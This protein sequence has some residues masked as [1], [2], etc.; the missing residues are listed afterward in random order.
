[1]IAL[2]NVKVSVRL[3]I[4]FML[5]AAFGAVIGVV[6]I[7]NIR[8]ITGLAEGMY[9]RHVLGLA[10][11]EEASRDVLHAVYAE[12]NLMLAQSEDQRQ[13]SKAQYDESLKQLDDAMANAKRL[14]LSDEGKKVIARLESSLKDWRDASQ[15]TVAAAM[16]EPLTSSR[17]AA[18]VSSQAEDDK[19][20]VVDLGMT[21]LTNLKKK[22]ARGLADAMGKIAQTN[23]RIMICLVVGSVVL[24][25]LVGIGLAS[26][27]ARQLGCEPSEM[28]EMAGRISRGDL[29][30]G[31][32]ARR[33]RNAIGAFASLQEMRGWLIQIVTTIQ[34]CASQ[35]SASSEQIA[36]SAQKLAEGT[37][38][39]ASAVEETSASMEELSASVD[40][41][42]EKARAQSAAMELGSTS[43]AQVQSSIA[44]ASEN[45]EEIGNLA[46]ESVDNALAGGRS[47]EEVV[48][49]INEIAGSSERIGGI[50]SVISDIADQTNL[51][52]LNASIEA[53]RAGEHGRG[54]AVVAQEVG[55]LA[56]RSSTSTKEIEGLIRESAKNVAKGVGTASVSQKAMEQ[57]RVA[58]ERVKEMIGRVSASMSHQVEVVAE[59]SQAVENAKTTSKDISATTDE[60]AA[61]ARQVAEA[62]ERVNEWSQNAA[63]AAEEV[64]ASTE[65]LSRT[66]QT[67]QE[68]VQRFKV[69][70]ERAATPRSSL[71]S[72]LPV[73]T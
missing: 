28:M 59:F 55:K 5:V 54:F 8:S 29:T 61:S 31:L 33:K 65:L 18:S 38:S 7:A 69:R 26:G 66:S 30:V 22:N 20:K 9:N 21:D 53:A 24:G 64:S 63:S 1:M 32:E 34:D 67:L 14:T 46:G 3:T 50:L 70:E 58:S 12:R 40:Q 62:V 73:A 51:L 45:V 49:G 15:D 16:S 52:A 6:A 19:L 42:A 57:I 36:A 44:Q 68:L 4:G 47:V 13:G 37:Q 56:E 43:M 35:V 71:A 11:S 39:Q 17:R 25:I 10:S 72:A 2:K 60:Q 41:V 48:G 23:L 27:I